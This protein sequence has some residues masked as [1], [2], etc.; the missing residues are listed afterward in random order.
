MFNYLIDCG[1][2]KKSINLLQSLYYNFS[3]SAPRRWS[4]AG[5]NANR[6]NMVMSVKPA[7]LRRKSSICAKL[8]IFSEITSETSTKN[9]TL[10]VNSNDRSGLELVSKT[11]GESE[12]GAEFM[13]CLSRCILLEV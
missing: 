1:W 8:R 5:V 2:A 3:I 12:I 4:A 6:L 13:I 11:N 7:Y 10:N 9:E